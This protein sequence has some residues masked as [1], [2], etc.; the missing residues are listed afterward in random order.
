M[1]FMKR[2][3]SYRWLDVIKKAVENCPSAARYTAVGD[4]ESD[5]YE[6]MSGFIQIKI[7]FVI[8]CSKNRNLS[9]LPQNNKKGN[10]S[11]GVAQDIDAEIHKNLYEKLKACPIAYAYEIDLP[12]TNQRSAHKAKVALKFCQVN[13]KCPNM[14]QKGQYLPEL[15]IYAVEV[16]EYPESVVG[17]EKPIH[18]IL[19]TSHPVQTIEQALE[20][21][22]WYRY[23]WI[24]EQSFRTTK[25]KGL[26]I[27]SSQAKSFEALA[28]LIT[29]A[30]IAA[31]QVMQLVQARDGQTQQAIENVFSPIEIAC[32]VQLNEQLEGKTEKQ[33]N[34]HSKKTLAFASWVMARLGGWTGYK[35]HRPPGPITIR[36]GMIRFY[37][38]LIGFDI[39]LQNYDVNELVYA[40]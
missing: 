40:L 37:N 29:L 23:R 31:V 3:L 22:Q 35:S 6:V 26:A 39:K 36:D 10:S 32:L 25:T 7:D 2:L 18:W 13:L 21:I 28:I 34:P 38:I 19:L 9:S 11:D 16:T 24:I 27:E 14:K 8:R 4:R 33:K 30:L 20:I 17:N 12:K 1:F 15:P 5:I